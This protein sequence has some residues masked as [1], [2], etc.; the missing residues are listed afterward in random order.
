MLSESFREKRGQTFDRYK[1][2]W[3]QFSSVTASDVQVTGENKLSAR[4]TYHRTN[5]ETTSQTHSYQMSQRNG[6]WQIDVEN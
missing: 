2:W 3:T 4:I 6:T 1:S 5:G